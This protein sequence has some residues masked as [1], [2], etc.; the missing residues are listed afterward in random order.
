MP[1]TLQ[2]IDR[3]SLR[4][5]VLEQ[6]RSAILNSELPL[7]SRINETELAAKLGTS[8]GPVREALSA[9]AREGLVEIRQGKGS[10]VRTP[11]HAE[12]DEIYDLRQ[13]LERHSM[14]LVVKRITDRDITKLRRIL[15]EMK[16]AHNL[17]E[18]R[19]AIERDLE[20]HSEIIRISGHKLLHDLHSGLANKVRMFVAAATEQ[21]DFE[22][23]FKSHYPILDALSAR[24]PKLAN[25]SIRDHHKIVTQ[26]IV[27]MLP[28]QP[29]DK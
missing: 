14:P 17:K 27:N 6:V 1:A 19:R 10:Y 2:Q 5:A 23:M 26:E 8:R 16:K 29:K 7:G 9:L 4:D 12:L 28:S 25:K 22:K 3:E 20:F 24:D 13:L 15:N 11:T 18:R 21:V